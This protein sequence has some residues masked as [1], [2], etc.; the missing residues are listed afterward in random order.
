M[1]LIHRS[2]S[3]DWLID[4][5]ID[6]VDPRPSHKKNQSTT[7]MGVVEDLNTPFYHA[8][9]ASS[10][11]V[12]ST[13]CGGIGGGVGGDSI[14]ID[15]E[16]KVL[17]QQYV[18]FTKLEQ[19]ECRRRAILKRSELPFWRI[20]GYF[21]GTCL[22]SICVDWLLW[23][24]V[25]VYSTLRVV[26]RNDDL[27]PDVH[28][29]GNTDLTIIGGFLS[30][31]LV[32]FVNQSNT[33]F[34]E[35]YKT[36]MKCP[37][38]ICDVAQI[39]FPTFP[40]P[41]AHRLIRYMNAAHVAG[42]V[43]LSRTYSKVEFFDK[44]ND[45]YQFLTKKELGRISELDMDYSPAA[46]QELVTWCTTDIE[47]AYRQSWIDPR[48]KSALKDKV[49]QFRTSMDELFDQ[50]DQPVHFFYIHFLCLLSAVY[51]PLF[52]ADNAFNA[53]TGEDVFWTWDV[54]SGIIVLVQSIF[55]IGLRLLGQ[56]MADPFG[57]DLEDLSV[58]TYVTETWVKSNRILASKNPTQSTEDAQVA[59]EELAQKRTAS[60][61]SPFD[62]KGDADAAVDKLSS[63][64]SPNKW[65]LPVGKKACIV[66]KDLFSHC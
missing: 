28:D 22:R 56:K 43:G 48:E 53:G 25:G 46:Y 33:R 54:L 40:R 10:S 60:L 16:Q 64:F 37:E 57:D 8:A 23:L 36:A 5:L 24:T 15:P 7:K 14:F 26:L 38:R 55:V 35:C 17:E 32:L 11:S 50:A 29:F 12:S 30:F 51:L 62:D 61:G 20:L 65:S 41:Y 47:H 18:P 31:F 58:L 2:Q 3:I 42:Y 1:L 63:W 45:K 39:V 4:W 27:L 66:T 21:E 52:A 19:I 44:L 49:T 34:V 13:T 59:E 9:A 6:Q